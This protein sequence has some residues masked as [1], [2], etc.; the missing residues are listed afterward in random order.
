MNQLNL[1][2]AEAEATS[3]VLLGNFGEKESVFCLSLMAQLRDA[4]I[5]TELYPDAVKLGKQ[6]SYASSRN[7]PFVALVG[8]N[9]IR[10]GKV[11]LKR[12]SDGE[13][14]SYTLTDLIEYLKRQ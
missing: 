1:F 9:E 10:E 12:L 8:D 2:P 4:G 14:Q 3:K 5:R 7:I 13:Q 11:T 6:I